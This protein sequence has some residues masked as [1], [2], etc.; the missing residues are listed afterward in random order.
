MPIRFGGGRCIDRFGG[1]GKELNEWF[2]NVLSF[3]ASSSSAPTP[4]VPTQEQVQQ[5][6]EMGISEDR[7]TLALTRSQGNLER[8]LDMLFS[9]EI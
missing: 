2:Q 7:A 9:G 6:C 1:R 3:A 5:M 4:F 8:A